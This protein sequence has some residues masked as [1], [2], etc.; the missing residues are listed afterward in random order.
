[1]SRR[2]GHR[3]ARIPVPV[4]LRVR[5]AQRRWETL[6]SRANIADACDARLCAKLAKI[7][8]QAWRRERRAVRRLLREATPARIAR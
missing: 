5:R 3:R 1:M 2:T 7:R 6:A 4:A 8:K